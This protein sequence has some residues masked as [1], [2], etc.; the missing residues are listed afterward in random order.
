MY[1]FRLANIE[2]S[3]ELMSSA[4]HEELTSTQEK[5]AKSGD[6]VLVITLTYMRKKTFRKRLLPYMMHANSTSISMAHGC[7]ACEQDPEVLELGV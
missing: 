1:L 4:K 5:A 7:K 6:R 2:H 3:R